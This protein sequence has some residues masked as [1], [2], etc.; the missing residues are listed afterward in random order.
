[1][2]IRISGLVDAV[3]TAL[4]QKKFV[5]CEFSGA[6][7]ASVEIK[8][9][10]AVDFHLQAAKLCT[11]TNDLLKTKNLRQLN[12]KE[13]EQIRDLVD[14]T[15]KASRVFS[16]LYGKEFSKEA[17]ELSQAGL[18]AK[19]GGKIDS[20]KLPSHKFKEFT[21]FIYANHL[22]HQIQSLGHQLP[23]DPSI[24]V[25]GFYGPIKWEH[26][27]KKKITDGLVA[28]YAMGKELFRTNEKG[29]LTEDYTY[30]DGKIAKYNPLT[31][32][33]V[34]HYDTEPA[35]GKCRVEFWSAMR[36]PKGVTPV[37]FGDHNMLVLVDEKGKRYATGQFGLTRKVG[38]QDYLSPF[39]KKPGSIETPD[40]YLLLAKD[41]HSFMKTDI[42]LTKEQFNHL[43]SEVEKQKRD[44][45]FQVS[46]LKGN[47]SSNAIGLLKQVG[48]KI[49]N[50]L[51]V[52][53][54]LYRRIA[55]T[56]LVSFFDRIGSFIPSWVKKISFFMP[57]PYLPT[58]ALSILMKLLGAGDDVSIVRTIFCPWTLT[59]D[60]PFA[61]RAWQQKQEKNT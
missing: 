12:L 44:D 58:V 5:A 6:D 51:H 47:C 55:P 32:R 23:S 41:S 33:E 16:K 27:S 60:H 11:F 37:I 42:P 25:E 22:H 28:Y 4:N 14:V 1:M 19:L 34:R 61:A 46:L 59:I 48:I 56:F 43:K 13:K 53:D 9:M 2:S 21:D 52:M 17:S 54:L 30:M 26:V 24:S 35:T 40:R 10:N 49:D 29:V 36:D 57:I 15:Y 45:N 20:K 3:Q 31:S 38:W 50:R 8:S 18:V 39:S 7:V